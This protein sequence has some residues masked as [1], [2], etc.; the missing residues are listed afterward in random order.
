MFHIDYIIISL[1]HVSEANLRLNDA[2]A[3]IEATTPPAAVKVYL[4]M[5]TNYVY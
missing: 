2:R 1:H 5:Y 3:S 4:S